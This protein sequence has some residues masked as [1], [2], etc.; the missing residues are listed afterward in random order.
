MGSRRGVLATVGAV[1]ILMALA[2]FAYS[3]HERA[4]YKK[5]YAMDGKMAAEGRQRQR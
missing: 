3:E 4:Y 2:L 1:V 5:L